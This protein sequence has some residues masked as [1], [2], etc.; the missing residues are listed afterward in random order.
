MAVKP[1]WDRDTRTCCRID[2]DR[3][4]ATPEPGGPVPVMCQYHIDAFLWRVEQLANAHT[5]AAPPPP[6][7]TFRTPTDE[8]DDCPRCN[9]PGA[10]IDHGRGGC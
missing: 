2:C 10:R 3:L 8:S 6:P 4:R 9:Q 5:P 1:Q 7:V